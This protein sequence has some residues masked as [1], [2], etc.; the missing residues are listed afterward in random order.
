M[1][2]VCLD[3]LQLDERGAGVIHQGDDRDD[4]G[5]PQAHPVN[6]EV[7]GQ[8]IRVPEGQHQRQD[9]AALGQLAPDVGVNHHVMGEHVGGAVDH[10]QLL[11]DHNDDGDH[12]EG[13]VQALHDERGAD[14]Q[15][16]SQGV[17]Q[18]AEV[19]DEVILAG[20]VAVQPVGEGGDAE[21][22]QRQLFIGQGVQDDEHGD[23]RQA[24]HRQDV[25]DIPDICQILLTEAA[26]GNKTFLRAGC[27]AV[28]T[29]A[30]GLL[31]KSILQ[32]AHEFDM[33][34]QNPAKVTNC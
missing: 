18:L 24:D 23:Q 7:H 26:H 9:E 12:R 33:K 2:F 10:H 29:E 3:L 31:R 4:H 28:C 22:Q 5:N 27:P 8:E 20:D 16:V 32:D 6:G 11:D 25:G 13:A 1:L 17:H 34:C 14:H 15:L 19:G 30:R 21:G